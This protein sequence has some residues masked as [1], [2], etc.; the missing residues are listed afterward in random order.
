MSAPKRRVVFKTTPKPRS[1]Y[2]AMTVEQRDA[3]VEQKVQELHSINERRVKFLN[4]DSIMEEDMELT[5]KWF[6]DIPYHCDLYM[7]V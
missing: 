4:Q 1:F 5:T 6:Y 7:I 2:K 3:Y